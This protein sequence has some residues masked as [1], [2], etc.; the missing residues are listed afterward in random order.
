MYVPRWICASVSV[1]CH[2]QYK[3][4]K[5]PGLGALLGTLFHLRELMP[6]HFLWLSL[7]YMKYMEMRQKCISHHF[8]RF[9]DVKMTSTDT[10]ISSSAYTCQKQQ[11][12]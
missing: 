2:R 3:R 10:L 4:R 7:N 6:G 9:F 12:Q 5:T 8:S 11:Q 1:S